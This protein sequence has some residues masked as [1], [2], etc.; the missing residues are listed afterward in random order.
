MELIRVFTDHHDHHLWSTMAQNYLYLRKYFGLN[1]SFREH[2]LRQAAIDAAITRAYRSY[3][4][5]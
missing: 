2:S 4:V 3:K 5:T 1:L